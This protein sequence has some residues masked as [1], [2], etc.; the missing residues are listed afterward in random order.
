MTYQQFLLAA[1]CAL[2][3]IGCA[4]PVS[5]GKTVGASSSAEALNIPRLPGLDSVSR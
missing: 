1:V 2:G 5:K 4:T 3:L